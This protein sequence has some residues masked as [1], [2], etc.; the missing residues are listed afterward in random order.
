M[1][2]KSSVIILTLLKYT[3]NK[4]RPS[5]VT[6]RISFEWA[7]RKSITAKYT[8]FKGVHAGITPVNICEFRHNRRIFTE[9]IVRTDRQTNQSQK[10]FSTFI[11]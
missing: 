3:F 10:H 9:V 2:Y 8:I 6:Y 11:G 1:T 5:T 4:Y 7:C